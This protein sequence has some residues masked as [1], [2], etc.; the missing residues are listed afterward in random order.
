MRGPQP[1]AHPNKEAIELMKKMNESKPKGVAIP[2][3]DLHITSEEQ[4]R[5]AIKECMAQM[6]DVTTDSLITNYDSLSVD[7]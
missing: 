7:Q 6:T 1:Y 5:D 4:A 2:L 3:S